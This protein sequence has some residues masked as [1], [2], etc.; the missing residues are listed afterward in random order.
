[1]D[2]EL[3]AWVERSV[4]GRVVVADRAPGGGSREL[5]LVDVEQPDGTVLPLVLRCEAGSSF[6][7]TEVSPAKEAV[8]YPRAGGHPGS[9][10]ARRR[11]RTW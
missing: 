11:T 7:G 6:T 10:T 1:M 8:V 3:R 5:Y 9:G 2:D 4:R